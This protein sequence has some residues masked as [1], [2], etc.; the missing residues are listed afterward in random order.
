MNHSQIL[1]AAKDVLNKNWN[2]HFTKP[3]PNLYPH[4]LNCDSGFIAIGLAHFNMDRAE[5][6]LRHLFKGQW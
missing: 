6:E 3:A 2:G 1:D 4:Q 5:A